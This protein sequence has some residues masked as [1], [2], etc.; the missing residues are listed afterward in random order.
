[1]LFDIHV[2][3]KTCAVFNMRTPGDIV[4]FW[5]SFQGSDPEVQALF[6]INP[7][8]KLEIYFHGSLKYL[9]WN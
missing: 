9:S 7:V 1:M 8:R 2:P 5:E 3:G 4:Y 6:K